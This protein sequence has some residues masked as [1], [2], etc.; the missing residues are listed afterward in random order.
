MFIINQTLNIYKNK[1]WFD[2]LIN[3]LNFFFISE[4]EIVY[5]QT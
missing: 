4:P 3:S 5:F 2:F 1:N